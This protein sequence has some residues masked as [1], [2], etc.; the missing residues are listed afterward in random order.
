M[1]GPLFAY[2]HLSTYTSLRAQYWSQ[3]IRD[4]A[5]TDCNMTCPMD[6]PVAEAPAVDA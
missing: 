4:A 5:E 1:Q 2:S 6:L 3:Q